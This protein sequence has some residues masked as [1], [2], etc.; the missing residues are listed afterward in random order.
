M[1]V[2]GVDA[3]LVLLC[4]LGVW[5][6]SWVFRAKI[7]D[8]TAKVFFFLKLVGCS[9]DIDPCLRE[10]CE[11]RTREESRTMLG[12]LILEGA[13]NC[14]LFNVKD[15]EKPMQLYFLCFPPSS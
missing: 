15:I 4:A 12:C 7:T 6:P 9:I 2:S 5:E 3:V 13:M 11:I 1:S 14:R 10:P 8:S